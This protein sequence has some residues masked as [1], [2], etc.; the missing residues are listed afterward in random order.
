MNNFEETKRAPESEAV[1]FKRKLLHPEKKKKDEAPKNKKKNLGLILTCLFMMADVVLKFI[2]GSICYHL[3]STAYAEWNEKWH[4]SW[5]YNTL[6]GKKLNRRARGADLKVGFAKLYE[7]SLLYR[8]AS[9]A[10][11]SILHSFVRLWGVTIFIFAF[12]MVFVAMAKYFIVRAVLWDNIFIG[13]VLGFLALPFVISKKR[14]GEMLISGKISKFITVDLLSVDET[15]YKRDDTKSGGNYFISIVVAC[16]LGLLTYF[17]DPLMII[18]VVAVI[19]TFAIIMCFPEFG[20]VATLTL[21]PF[22]GLLDHPSIAILVIVI[23]TTCSYVFK[24]FRG[25]RIIHF[26]LMDVLVTIFGAM[27]LFGG[28]FTTGGINSLQSGLLYF[29]FLAFYGLIVNSYIRKTW[30]YRGIKIIALTTTVVALIGIFEDGIVSASWVDMTMFGDMGARVS[31]LLGN[32]NML[33]IYL[34]I[35]F[36][37]VFAHV[38]TSE[39]IVDKIFYVF[40]T[41]AVLGCTVLTWSRGAWLGMFVS[42]LVFL[43]LYN[44]RNI[45]VIFAGLFSVPLWIGFLP[46]NFLR[47]LFSIV[48]FSDSSVIYRFNTWKATANMIWDN[49]FTGV[50]VGES[51]FKANYHRYA[52]A[53]TEDVMHAHNLILEIGVELGIVALLIFVAV[54]IMYTQKCMMGISKKERGSHSRVMIIAGFSSIAG[55]LV[56][57]ITDYIWYNYRVFLIFWAV[58]GLT[59]ALIRINDKQRAKELASIVNDRESAQLEIY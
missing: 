42:V 4:N 55:A 39:K 41:L 51:A 47:R 50:G 18:F 52:I 3:I 31:S 57:G 40:C 35:A 22:A 34:L 29:A 27:F 10:S 33:G 21:L 13:L 6:K 30:I 14:F 38:I 9:T 25:K 59:V 56:M 11:Q 2:K 32:P 24:L 19:A 5:I 46:E 16:V 45:W 49:L 44:F 28:V 26:D 36:P 8:F 7:S 53:G 1:A 43:V 37:F 58:I 23:F 12:I 15:R 17:V 20:I 54:M 48:Q